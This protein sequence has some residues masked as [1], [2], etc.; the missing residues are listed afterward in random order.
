LFSN[1]WEEGEWSKSEL[2]VGNES[3]KYYKMKEIKKVSNI[4][5]EMKN[6]NVKW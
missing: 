2:K 4:D 3:V 6:L 5:C 1:F